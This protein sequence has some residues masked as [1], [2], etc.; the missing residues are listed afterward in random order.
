MRYLGHSII[1]FLKQT[2]QNYYLL[3]SSNLKRPWL[4]YFTLF[5]QNCAHLP[6]QGKITNS[7]N[8][9]NVWLATCQRIIA[10]V[11]IASA[12]AMGAT[13][14][15]SRIIVHAFVIVVKPRDPVKCSKVN[16]SKCFC[17]ICFLI[18]NFTFE[19]KIRI[20]SIA[21]SLQ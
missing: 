4:I 7:R 14:F 13:N 6:R 1:D 15:L 19:N 18:L 10:F 17:P 20:N 11:R 2:S 9:S 21:V 3:K 5:F 12:I 8:G 16:T